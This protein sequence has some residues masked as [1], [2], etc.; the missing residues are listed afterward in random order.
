MP[1]PDGAIERPQPIR[2]LGLDGAPVGE[3]PECDPAR[4]LEF[5]RLLVLTRALD[6]GFMRLQRQ[7]ELGVYAPCRGQ[8]AA[9]VATAGALAPTDWIVPSYRELGCAVARGVPVESII[10]TWRGSWFSEVDTR[11]H[12]FLPIAIPVGTNALH[13][14]GLALGIKQ[15][16]GQEVVAVYFGDGATSEGDVSE[17]FNAAAVFAV[18]CIFVVQNNGWAIS[19]PTA[20][21]YASA[22]LAER[23]PAFGMPGWRVDGNDVMACWWAMAQAVE[24]CRR[25]QG[26]MLLELLTYRMGPHTTSDDP[27]RYRSSDED[28]QWAA[29]DPIARFESYLLSRQLITPDL[30]DEHRQQAEQAVEALRRAV[31]ACVDPSPLEVF[32][33]VYHQRPATL[34]AQREAM[35]AEIEAWETST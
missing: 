17:A 1:P 31:L 19:T 30:V 6:D 9:Q 28:R 29:A 7:G 26:P 34:Q 21:Q 35:A 8:E 33:H 4:L 10:P 13:A 2:F 5:H 32:E 3:V 20:R 24:H 11:R 23:G 16:G 15:Q 27:S 18:P 14:V 22:T 12:R 25:G